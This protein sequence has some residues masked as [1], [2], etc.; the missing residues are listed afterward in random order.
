MNPEELF[1]KIFG[2]AGFQTSNFSEYDEYADSKYGFGGA[3][4][5]HFI[6]LH[7]VNLI[8]KNIK[9]NQYNNFRSL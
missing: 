6:I 1:R 2:D 4:E 3:Q 8:N 9:L 7:I 5:V